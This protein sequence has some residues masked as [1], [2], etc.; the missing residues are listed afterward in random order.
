MH[1]G[2]RKAF[3]S[4]GPQKLNRDTKSNSYGGVIKVG[5]SIAPLAPASRTYGIH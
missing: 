2:H 4:G 1:Q 3:M 5:G